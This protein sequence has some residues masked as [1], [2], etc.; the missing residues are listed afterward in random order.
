MERLALFLPSFVVI[1][2]IGIAATI[3]I[4]W[5]FGRH[6]NEMRS[7]DWREENKAKVGLSLSMP[8]QYLA[9]PTLEELAFRA[10]LILLFPV[11]TGNAWIGIV[12]SSVLFGALHWFGGKA[13][14]QLLLD[15]RRKGEVHGDD[16][17]E[18]SRQYSQIHKREILASRIYH[19]I[20]T[21]GLG[22]VLG[23]CAIKYQSIWL[24]VGLHALWNALMP[25]L[26]MLAF[27]LLVLL[28]QLITALPRYI[29]RQWSLKRGIERVMNRVIQCAEEAEP[30]LPKGR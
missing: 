1:A 18:V 24:V 14:L 6:K 28:V 25:V 8:N 15:A 23:Y 17:K 12:V 22:L 27:I 7:L 19:V 3:Y 29:Y 30:T 13:G 4:R 2:A 10:P 11:V 5:F 21:T 26:I 9:S 16:F 20:A